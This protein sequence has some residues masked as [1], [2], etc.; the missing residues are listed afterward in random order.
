MGTQDWTYLRTHRWITF[1]VD[2]RPAPASLWMN[3]G[4]ARSKFDH[5]AGIPL[6]PDVAGLLHNVYLA[7]GVHGTTAIEG[8]TLTE[9]EIRKHMEGQ[10]K[11][12]LSQAYL[13]QEIDNI[14]NACN[15]IAQ[16]LWHGKPADLT[17]DRICQFNS[18][19]L[20]KLE[21]ETD[22]TPGQIRLSSVGVGS[23]LGAPAGECEYLTRKLC[24]WLSSPDFQGNGKDTIVT[25]ILK[26]ILAHLYIA[27]I[28]PFADGNG[29]TA[30]LVEFQILTAAG[31][32][33]PAAHLLS[34]HYNKTRSEYY[35]QLEMASKSGGDVIPFIQYAVQGLIDG[36]IGQLH[37]IRNYQW[38]VTWQNYVHDQFGHKK[39]MSASELRQH[40]LAMDLSDKNG[41]VPLD[42]IREISPRITLAYAK[43]SNKTLR[44]DLNKL[45]KFELV[46]ETKEGF[47]AKS[48]KILAFLPPRCSAV[49]INPAKAFA[50]AK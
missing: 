18:M 25:A 7:K 42:K 46:E 3:L 49:P 8:N 13:K 31:V 1:S 14:I 20:N 32:P 39:A 17:F 29:R 34:N 30:R 28:H 15:G 48:E 24:E 6:R 36:L 37:A 40:H 5:I 43:K 27:W 41:F 38:Q 21:L 12:P 9:D 16:D 50:T 45:K 11:L 26:A 19:V 4:E 33:S 35:R 22:E 10:L 44:R 47:R 2:L 23:Y